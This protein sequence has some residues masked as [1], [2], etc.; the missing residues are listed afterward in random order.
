MHGVPARQVVLFVLFSLPFLNGCAAE[1]FVSAPEERVILESGPAA[2]NA[3]RETRYLTTD[4]QTTFENIRNRKSGWRVNRKPHFDQGFTPKTYWLRVRIVNRAKN[5]LWYLSLRNNRLDYVDFFMVPENDG[6]P[7]TLAAGD[8]RP[9]PL[10]ATTSY[11]LFAF[12]LPADASAT[13]FVRIRTDTHVSFPVRFYGPVEFGAE[14]QRTMLTQVLF[15]V[16]MI[17]YLIFQV[18]FNPGVNGPMEIFLSLMITSGM[19]YA[20]IYLGE[21]NRLLW[22][23]NIWAKNNVAFIAI[24]HFGLFFLLFLPGFLRLKDFNPRLLLIYRIYTIVFAGMVISFF[25]PIANKLKNDLITIFMPLV[26]ILMLVGIGQALRRGRYWVLYLLTC[27]ILVFITT[28]GMLLMLQGVL[29]YNN[30]TAHGPIL[31]F[32]VDVFILAVSLVI[33]HRALMRERDNLRSRVDELIKQG[34]GNEA[35]E[36]RTQS[37]RRISNLDGAQVLRDLAQLFD[38][39][40]PYL[41]EALT[42]AGVAEKL[43]IRPDQLSAIIN[44]ELKTSFADLVNEYRIR[45]ARKLMRERPDLNLLRIAFDCGFGS[46]ASFNRVFKQKMD[47][48]PVE[49]RRRLEQTGD[50]E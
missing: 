36:T 10:G 45:A 13:I 21:G 41:E 33:R 23:D 19:I 25:F 28:V 4:A 46:R 15:V 44:K 3:S 50:T 11:P 16:L 34:A 39:E 17:I 6:P 47:M 29:P 49:Y 42:L 35:P 37:S 26:Y 20:F 2:L 38:R 1:R 12:D 27:W 18:R 32:P 7:R 9:L 43:E 40:Q 31:T 5:T 8:H 30:F 22:P 24:G 48:P 14:L